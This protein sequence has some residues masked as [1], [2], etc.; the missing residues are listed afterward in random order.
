MTMDLA[1]RKRGKGM[2]I[3]LILLLAAG[4]ISYRLLVVHHLEQ[5]SAMFIGLPAILAIGVALLPR[6]ESATA[7]IVKVLSIFLLLSGV[8]L[9]EGFI[10]ILM[11]TPLVLGMGAI[12]GVIID[13]NRRPGA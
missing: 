4:S 5:T 10:C 2:V 6:S 9:G 3:G 11:A 1:E 8:L 13:N 7:A 12:I